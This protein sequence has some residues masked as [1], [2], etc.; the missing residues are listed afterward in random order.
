MG[1]FVLRMTDS[2]MSRLDGVTDRHLQRLCCLRWS[3]LPVHEWILDSRGMLDQPILTQLEIEI[4]QFI[5]GERV[6]V[7]SVEISHLCLFLCNF[8]CRSSSWV[9][10]CRL[11]SVFW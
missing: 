2:V 3:H 1:P 4:F 11:Q 5:D 10:I 7:S 9:G 8:R 6:V